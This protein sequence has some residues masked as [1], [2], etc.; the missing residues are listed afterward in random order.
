M[1]LQVPLPSFVGTADP[2][3]IT[4]SFL[5]NWGEH[6]E[7]KQFIT[8]TAFILE[9]VFPL[10]SLRAI[11]AGAKAW[12]LDNLPNQEIKDIKLKTSSETLAALTTTCLLADS[13]WQPSPLKG[14]QGAT[15]NLPQATILWQLELWHTWENQ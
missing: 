3:S 10:I 7:A 9:E 6:P 2:N 1:A 15:V 8:N 12:L 14:K 5:L 13:S 11:K 4:S